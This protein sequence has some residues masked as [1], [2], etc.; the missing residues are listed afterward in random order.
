M[1]S[2]KPLHTIAVAIAFSQ[3]FNSTVSAEQPAQVLS[4][5][6]TKIELEQDATLEYAPHRVLVRFRKDTP[7]A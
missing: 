7:L 1:N 5:Q 3:L 6:L 2:I 4:D